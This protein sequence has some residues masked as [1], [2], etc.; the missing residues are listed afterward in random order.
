[1]QKD[2]GVDFYDAGHEK[3]IKTKAQVRLDFCSNHLKN[4]TASLAEALEGLEIGEC[5]PSVAS[6][7]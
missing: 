3:E 1:M 2:R 4:L 6:E 5:V 7:W